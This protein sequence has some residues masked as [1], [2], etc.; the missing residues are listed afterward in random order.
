MNKKDELKR[1]IKKRKNSDCLFEFTPSKSHLKMTFILSAILLIT[2][3][4]DWVF[5]L[6]LF[7][8]VNLPQNAFRIILIVANILIPL[9]TWMQYDTKVR[10]EKKENEE[11]EKLIDELKE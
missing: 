1:L 11:I 9:F 7:T 3:V 2:T 8:Y 6:G 4:I 10:E 5:N